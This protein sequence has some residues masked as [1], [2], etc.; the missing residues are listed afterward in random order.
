MKVLFDT[1]VLMDVFC[2]REPHYA[3]SAQVVNLAVQGYIDALV[4]GHSID[5]IHYLCMRF[6]DR[7]QADSIVDWLL[8]SFQI[9]AATRE[10]YLRARSLYFADFEDSVV[11]AM[12]EA[13]S[14][15]FI[16]TRNSSDFVLSPV[17]AVV[18]AELLQDYSP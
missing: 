10:I 9:S 16:V 12:A 18:P 14:C 4:P 5:T 11:A 3:D 13:D 2:R 6:L 8:A 17:I 1:N 15:D 7:D